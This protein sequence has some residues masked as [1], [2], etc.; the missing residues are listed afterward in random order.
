M[1]S[2]R[3]EEE[4]SGSISLADLPV[5]LDLAKSIALGTSLHQYCRYKMLNAA[6][7]IKIISNDSFEELTIDII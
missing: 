3:Y 1:L 5:Y 2:F 7:N 6:I 4:L